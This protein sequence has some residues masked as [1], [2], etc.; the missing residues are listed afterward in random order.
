MDNT[1]FNN[2][3]AKAVA[4]NKD[5][6]NDLINQSYQDLFYYALKI[7]RDEDKAY[8]ALQNGC[9]EI[10]KTIGNLRENAAFI[11]W[12]RRI[13]YHHCLKLVGKSRIVTLEE[14]EDGETILDLI[15]DETPGSLPQEVVENKELHDILQG[16]IDSLPGNQRA[17]LML[18]HFEH[19]PIK[20]IAIIQG[21]KEATVK[22]HLH[23]GRKAMEK[24]IEEYEKKTGT[25]LHCVGVLPLLY[26]LFQNDKAKA[27]TASAALWPQLQTAIA[28]TIAA[29][30]A[31]TSAAAGTAIFSTLAFK[32]GATVVAAALVVG[33]VVISTRSGNEPAETEA[34]ESSYAEPPV[35]VPGA[36]NPGEKHP[37]QHYAFDDEAH[38]LLCDCPGVTDARQTHSFV[39]GECVVCRMPQPLPSGNP[40]LDYDT[41]RLGGHWLY[42]P[43]PVYTESTGA[44]EFY[45]N[46]DGSLYIDSKTYYPVGS[47]FD[48]APVGDPCPL[49]LYFRETPFDPEVGITEM[50]AYSAPITLKL[51]SIDDCGVISLT[52]INGDTYSYGDY[53]R[54]SDYFD[55]DKVEL[56]L[57][58][59]RDY[60]TITIDPVG[61]GYS[62]GTFYAYSG[63]QFTLKEGLGEASCIQIR[64]S[65]VTEYHLVESNIKTQDSDFTNISTSPEYTDLRTS[66]YGTSYT[67]HIDI[68]MGETVPIN[69]VV[70]WYGDIPINLDIDSISGY[71]FVPKQ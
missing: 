68:M 26:F 45:I 15:P 21:E 50:E 17:A 6:L 36:P 66:F 63:I 48:D 40:Y 30:G 42:M 8:D 59:Y 5:A 62:Y 53:Y 2:L 37:F 57:D 20:E 32:I 3:V 14:N 33:G 13:I 55:Y 44:D 61:C 19:I 70:K 46:G 38:W 11:T 28:P 7:V 9:E 56:T 41:T 69:N 31:G 18:F 27:D 47:R 22:T 35:L 10:L 49:L 25:K 71:V 23:R 4:G 60:L 58:N 16:M 64:G 39:D 1:A 54:E 12:S 52:I 29:V 43:M 24:K 65:I 34:P 51:K 67:K